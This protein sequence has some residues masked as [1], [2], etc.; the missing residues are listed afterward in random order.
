M[1]FVIDSGKVKEVQSLLNSLIYNTKLKRVLSIER[2]WLMWLVLVLFI[3]LEIIRYTKSCIYVKECLDLQSECPAKEG[4]VTLTLSKSH[5]KKM[6]TLN[7]TSQIRISLKNVKNP[8][9][10]WHVHRAGRC[11][12]GICFHLFSRLRFN[13]M[14]EFQVPQLLRMALQVDSH[15][16]FHHLSS[17][18]NGVT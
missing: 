17:K 6:S 8:L 2:C 18:K 3:F 16:V 11:R 10:V 5:F 1:V 7:F 4:K 9:T 12:P 13:N 15:T 14:Q